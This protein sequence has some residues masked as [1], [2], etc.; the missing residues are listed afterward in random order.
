[1]SREPAYTDA[2]IADL[3]LIRERLP[4]H[5]AIIMDGNGRWAQQRGLPR[6]E[7]HRRGVKSVRATVEECSRLGMEQLTLYCF[8]SENWK[9]PP[10]ELSLLMKLLRHYLLEERRQ[11]QEQGLRFRVIGKTEE[12]DPVI[13]EEI[14]ITEEVAG[15]NTG[16]MLCLAINYGARLEIAEAAARIA[17]QVRD[18]SL[19]PEDVSEETVAD[20]LMTA[21]M[22]DPDLV[23]RTANEL[24]ISN[25]LLWQLSYA[26]LW[27][28]DSFW[29][30]FRE[31]HL[32]QALKDFAS[33]NR[34]FGGLNSSERPA[35]QVA[36][37]AD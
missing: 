36:D 24:R 25:F 6:V 22:P 8:S 16:M 1:M 27:I 2:Q 28:T 11:I 35:A 14:A 15:Q 19:Q 7:G 4:R 12:L 3:G 29:P 31:P 32:H 30:E 17:Q 13:Q 33:R 18:G 26:E 37:H 34:R 10:R 5:V 20:N 23:I 9:R 21:G